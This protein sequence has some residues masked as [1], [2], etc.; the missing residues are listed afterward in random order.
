MIKLLAS[1]L[2]TFSTQRKRCHCINPE[3]R[4]TNQSSWVHCTNRFFDD[5]DL[6]CVR[7]LTRV[8][9]NI[10]TN[11]GR[12]KNMYSIFKSSWRNLRC[13]KSYVTMKVFSKCWPLSFLALWNTLNRINRGSTVKSLWQFSERIVRKNAMTFFRSP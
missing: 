4:R 9:S 12:K 10:C 3:A 11:T 5:L 2:L 8:E 7:V 6:T 13:Q 1:L